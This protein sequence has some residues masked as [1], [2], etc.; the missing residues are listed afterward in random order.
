MVNAKY[1]HLYVILKN[2]VTKSIFILTKCFFSISEPYKL[3]QPFHDG[4]R[5]YIETGPLICSANQW[6]G[7]YMIRASDVKG[8]IPQSRKVGNGW[9]WKWIFIEI[10]LDRRLNFPEIKGFILW[11][12]KL[13]SVVI[14]WKRERKDA[15][16]WWEWSL[17][18]RDRYI[19]ESK[20]LFPYREME[21]WMTETVVRR[22][23]SK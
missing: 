23:S 1:I 13:I 6:T 10:L 4:G 3:S 19:P 14:P 12:L 21:V 2:T 20:K 9:K 5:Y 17:R 16:K 7:F 8:L 22:R 18:I 15:V 11:Y